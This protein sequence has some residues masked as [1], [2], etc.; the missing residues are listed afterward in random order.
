MLHPEGYDGPPADVWSAGVLALEVLIGTPDFDALWFVAYNTEYKRGTLM[1]DRRA[2]DGAD[3]HA[4]F[5]GV[6]APIVAAL[7]D[8][9][10]ALGA[11]VAR[12]AANA[13]VAGECRAMLRLD[14]SA[15]PT[16]AAVRDCLTTETV[17]TEL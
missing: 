4:N 15:R 17:V 1:Q 6:L 12:H 5:C 11:L 9:A 2:D 14:P 8:G 13:E 7:A 10:T 3:V 16:A